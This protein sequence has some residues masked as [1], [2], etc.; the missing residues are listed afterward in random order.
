MRGTQWWW[1]RCRVVATT[2]GTGGCG[3]R[4]VPTS[5]RVLGRD[6]HGRLGPKALTGV[7]FRRRDGIGHGPSLPTSGVSVPPSL[8]R[9]D[10]PSLLPG[11]CVPGGTV[12]SGTRPAD[13]R[14]PGLWG[15][16]GRG[17]W[18][19]TSGPRTVEAGAD[20]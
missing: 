9:P 1:E 3:S 14:F 20:P 2:G 4:G 16:E 12:V 6:S 11:S 19:W 15:S 10:S 5:G 17:K 13:D 8:F 18:R 7:G